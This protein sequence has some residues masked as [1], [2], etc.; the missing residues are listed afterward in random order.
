VCVAEE[1]R[2]R[3]KT[4]IANRGGRKKAAVRRRPVGLSWSSAMERKSRSEKKKGVKM[5]D[6]VAFCPLR[7]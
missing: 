3:G 4:K 7:K 6:R 1:K 2:S 5:L